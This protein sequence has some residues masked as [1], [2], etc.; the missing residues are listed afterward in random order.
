[1]ASNPLHSRTFSTIQ[2]LISDV[3][4]LQEIL[5]K[6]ERYRKE[7]SIK[8]QNH[9]H[10]IETGDNTLQNY[11]DHFRSLNELIESLQL[12]AQH[13]NSQQMQHEYNLRLQ[14]A[15]QMKAELQKNFQPGKPLPYSD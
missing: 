11:S 14:E 15:L 4:E 10:K 7:L 2:Y 9:Q 3:H 5:N 8:Y 1:M 12:F 6:L 13:V